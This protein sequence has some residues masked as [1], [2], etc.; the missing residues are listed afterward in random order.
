MKVGRGNVNE[1]HKYFLL[2]W[3]NP[4]SDK[5]TLFG[6]A[7]ILTVV[8]CWKGDH[9]IFLRDGVLCSSLKGLMS[10]LEFLRIN[11]RKTYSRRFGKVCIRDL[12]VDGVFGDRKIF[13]VM[14]GISF[15][16]STCSASSLKSRAIIISKPLL[17]IY[18]WNRIFQI[19]CGQ[20]NME[21]PNGKWFLNFDET[22]KPCNV[23]VL[24]TLLDSS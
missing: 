4:R 1:P 19:K 3:N 12:K 17:A 20:W 10:L 16:F 6:R 5:T 7:P 24:E 2:E 21:W 8:K 22:G 14:C 9:V 18:S 13:L 23:P 11:A 15:F